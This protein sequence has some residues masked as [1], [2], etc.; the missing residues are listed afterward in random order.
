MTEDNR[1]ERVNAAAIPDRQDAGEA[2]RR[3]YFRI[4]DRAILK[5]R[6]LPPGEREA[7]VAR[8][9]R[10]PATRHALA[11]T[12]ANVSQQMQHLLRRIEQT[13]PDIALC[14]DTLNEKL[15]ML[16]RQLSLEASQM[17]DEPVRAVNV[18]AAG[19]CF[20]A[21]DALDPGGLLELRLLLLPSYVGVSAVGTVVRCDE[22]APEESDLPYRIAVDFDYLRDDDRELLVQHVVRRETE[23][24]RDS[25]GQGSAP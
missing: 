21:E 23:Q 16:A 6:V 25:R 4:D 24:L 5:Y 14:L 13:E 19:I 22:T 3:R 17:A 15:D 12:F 2:E 10:A 18:S 7:I 1:L 20:E 9:S 8:L 11:N